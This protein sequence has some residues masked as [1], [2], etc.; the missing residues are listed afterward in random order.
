MTARRLMV[1]AVVRQATVKNV[2]Q[3]PSAW[4]APMVSPT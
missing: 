2:I 3:N 4:L 1:A